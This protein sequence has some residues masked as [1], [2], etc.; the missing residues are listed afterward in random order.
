[1][2]FF[3]WFYAPILAVAL[4]ATGLALGQD[5]RF[6]RI[7]TGSTAG[8]NFPIGGLIASV[9]SNPPGSRDCDRGGSCGVPG[10]IAVAQ[11]TQGSAENAREVGLGRL[12]AGIVQADVAAMA[13]EGRGDF[14]GKNRLPNLR[15][16]ASLYPE[17]MQIVVRRDSRITTLA[18]LKGKRISLDT[19]LS[20]TQPAARAVLAQAGIKIADIKPVYVDVGTATD[21]VR[22][23]KIDGFFYVGGHPAPAIAQLSETIDIRL[24]PVA[25][26]LVER[27]HKTEPHYLPGAIPANAY[28]GIEDTPTL[29]VQTLLVVNETLPEDLAYNILRS[30]WHRTARVM[31]S[32]G[33]PQGKMIRLATALDGVSIPLHPGAWR[34]YAELGLLK[35]G[36]QK[37]GTNGGPVRNEPAKSG[38]D[39]SAGGPQPNAA[40]E[41]RQQP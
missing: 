23:G 11:A 26:N 9:I 22:E 36:A 25:A 2:R 28:K 21:M 19:P 13:Y 4:G 20:G 15:A 31:L 37:T 17:T 18:G 33:H 39:R 1:M 10:M 24:V 7:G 8:A 12:D 6:F 29:S 32:S 27:L 30:L 35:D 41:S 40:G 14:S 34:Y 3:P 5:I 16:L 38:S